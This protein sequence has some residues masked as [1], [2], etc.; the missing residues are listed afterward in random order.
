MSNDQSLVNVESL[1]KMVL[2]F[3][4]QFGRNL[5]K[6]NDVDDELINLIFSAIDLVVNGAAGAAGSEASD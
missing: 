2:M 4:E 6:K 5:L 3:V 1:K